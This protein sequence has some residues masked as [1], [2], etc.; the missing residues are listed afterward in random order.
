MNELKTKWIP[1]SEAVESEGN[2][3]FKMED[4]VGPITKV[5]S[6]NVDQKYRYNMNTKGLLILNLNPISPTNEIW[7]EYYEN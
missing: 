3:L 7:I 1:I 2:Y 5:R 4:T 6:A